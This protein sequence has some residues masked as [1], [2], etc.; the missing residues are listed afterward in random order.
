VLCQG[1]VVGEV[2]SG[3][4]S[5]C[6]EVGVALARVKAAAAEQNEFSIDKG[7]RQAPVTKAEIPFYIGTARKKIG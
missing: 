5:P 6:L 7:R 1:E 4:L 3:S 2:T